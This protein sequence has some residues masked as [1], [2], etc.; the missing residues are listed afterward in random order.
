MKYTLA[1]FIQ[2]IKRE[3]DGREGQIDLQSDEALAV[4]NE[5][6]PRNMICERICLECGKIRPDD[7]RVK[8][9]MK[10]SYCAYGGG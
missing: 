6:L 8:A 1:D 5:C 10:C 4:I 2:N 3:A 9:G 7:D